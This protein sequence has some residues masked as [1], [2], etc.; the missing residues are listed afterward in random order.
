VNACV[1]IADFDATCNR[2]GTKFARAR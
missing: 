1:A 2:C